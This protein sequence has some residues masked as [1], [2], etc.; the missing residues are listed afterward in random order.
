MVK[1]G[2]SKGSAVSRGPRLRNLSRRQKRAKAKAETKSL[3]APISSFRLTGRS[4]RII[5]TYRK[6]FAGITFVYLVLSVIFANVISNIS[7]VVS[8]IKFDLEVGSSENL[9]PF[10]SALN[11]FGNLVGSAGTSSSST[12]SVLQTML[13]IM[14]SLVIIWAL[15]HLLAG[16]TI[17]VK[18]AYYESMTPL[19]PFLLV[20]LVILIQ[21]LPIGLLLPAVGAFLSA[22]FASGSTGNILFIIIGGLL[23]LWSLYMVSSSIF[24]LYIVTLPGMH[25]RKALKSAKNLVRFRRWGVMRRLLFLPIFILL[26]MGAIIIPLILWATFLVTPVFLLLSLLSLLFAHTYIYSLYR[27]LIK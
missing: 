5:I 24:A 19:V 18:Q 3:P 16:K 10:A 12:G 1:K 20:L 4:I 6:P 13:I 23:A 15:R 2:S 26:G 9:S 21:L 8:D 27:E 25:P 11:G 17:K 14:Q 7:G 22:V